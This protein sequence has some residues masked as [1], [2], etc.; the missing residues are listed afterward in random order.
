ME[1]LVDSYEVGSELQIV[2]ASF[3][4]LQAKVSP[5]MYGKY[6]PSAVL[7]VALY[8]PFKQPGTGDVQL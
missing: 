3:H 2:A 6:P 1:R 7:S 5:S 4:A 8:H